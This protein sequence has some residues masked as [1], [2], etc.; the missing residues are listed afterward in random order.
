MLSEKGIRKKR[1]VVGMSGGVDSSV[2]AALLLE[3]GYDVIGA[4]MELGTGM[5]KAVD[6]ARSV[7]DTLGIPHH[8]MN[9]RNIFN[10]KVIEYFITEYM[11]GKTPN[12]CVSCN[13]YI[14]FGEF[15]YEAKKLGAE[16]IAT[17]HYARI[18]YDEKA[19]RFFL[20]RAQDL[21]K[22]QS[23]VLYNLKQEQLRHILFPLGNYTKTMIREKAER[24]GLTVAN[25]AESQEICFIP[26][27]DYKG[28]LQKQKRSYII[29][30]GDFLNT[31]GEVIGKHKGLPYY[32]IGQ[33]KGLGLALGYPAY[34]AA[35]D[36]N[37][38]NVIIGHEEEIFQKGLIAINTSF[39]TFDKL[40]S[41]MKVEAKI[42]YSAIPASAEIS[43]EDN[44]RIR[45]IFNEP[46]RAI[47]PGQSVV[48]YSGD[49]V[50]GGGVIEEVMHSQD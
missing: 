38:N 41:P 12:P 25:K 40:D 47:T 20:L 13:R 34:V 28:F 14:K 10:E 35:I 3:E 39:I 23:Y 22:D 9:F 7:A 29:K 15:L 31:K 48:F 37:K 32:T 2:V 27:N 1:V 17:G 5:R 42:R 46:Q 44:D 6:D 16:Y 26:D 36:L 45:V 11:Q 30:P 8:V 33:R 50:I 21:S 4:T 43:P 24:L 18:Q 49:K 19:D